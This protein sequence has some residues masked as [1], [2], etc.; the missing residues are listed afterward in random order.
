MLAWRNRRLD[1][2][3]CILRNTQ[4]KFLGHTLNETRPL[5]ISNS[6]DLLKSREAEGKVNNLVGVN[7]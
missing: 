2:M 7:V 1:K 5:I 4:M 6:G 3:V